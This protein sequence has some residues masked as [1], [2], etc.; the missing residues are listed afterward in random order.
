MP[1]PESAAQ[2]PGEDEGECTRLGWSYASERG[3]PEGR[4]TRWGRGAAATRG[5]GDAGAPV[6][7][8]RC[9]D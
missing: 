4:L 5:A 6:G 3:G 9:G 8:V 1:Q 2:G 7:G